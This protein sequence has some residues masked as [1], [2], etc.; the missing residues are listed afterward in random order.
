MYT[1]TVNL[2]LKGKVQ[3]HSENAH[4]SAYL[5]NYL[6]EDGEFNEKSMYTHIINHGEQ[7][8]TLTSRLMVKVKV[9]M[10]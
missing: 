4:Q 1:Q 8:A 9:Q 6:S 7:N 10:K 3:G 5:A 2:T